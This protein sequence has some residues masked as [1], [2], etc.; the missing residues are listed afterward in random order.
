MQLEIASEAGEGD[1]VK[2]L[3]TKQR[4]L[5]DANR[6]WRREFVA[7]IE[8]DRLTAELAKT[9]NKRLEN[10]LRNVELETQLAEAN[11]TILKLRKT[12]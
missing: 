12:R 9:E 2:K 3:S 8:R 10:H 7:E 4:H 11:A 1:C 5:I 6:D